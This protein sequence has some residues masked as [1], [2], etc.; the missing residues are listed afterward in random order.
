M[1]GIFLICEF[2]LCRRVQFRPAISHRAQRS[3]ANG[4]KIPCQPHTD[5]WGLPLVLD[6]IARRVERWLLNSPKAYNQ[7]KLAWRSRKILN[8]LKPYKQIHSKPIA[9]TMA[10]QIQLWQKASF[11]RDPRK[12]KPESPS[13]TPLHLSEET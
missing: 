2:R 13:L 6:R 11:L 9:H 7:S 5:F 3:A 8:P 1:V 10:L 12:K 4:V